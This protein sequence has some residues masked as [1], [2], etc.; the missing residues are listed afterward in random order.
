MPKIIQIAAAGHE[1]VITTQCNVT[2]FALDDNGDVW[3]IGNQ[4]QTWRK[5]PPLPAEP[6]QE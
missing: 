2:L 5:L 6:K 3:G 1:N 4:D